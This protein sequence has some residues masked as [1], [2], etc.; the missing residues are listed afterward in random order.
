MT[1]W[2]CKLRNGSVSVRHECSR[3]QLNKQGITLE[4]IRTRGI[5]LVIIKGLTNF[6]LDPNILEICGKKYSTQ[7]LKPFGQQETKVKA[8]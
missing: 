3:F 4:Q 5:T 7:I 6:E 8:C 1:L 2:V